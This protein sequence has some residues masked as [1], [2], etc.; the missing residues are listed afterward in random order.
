MGSVCGFVIFVSSCPFLPG[1][2]SQG[3]GTGAGG[4]HAPRPVVQGGTMKTAWLHTDFARCLCAW[5]AGLL[6]R[7]RQQTLRAGWGTSVT[8][9]PS[10]PAGG[11]CPRSG[12]KQG[13]Y[14]GVRHF[15]RTELQP[16]STEGPWAAGAGRSV[17]G[18]SVIP[19]PT[20]GTFCSSHGEREGGLEDLMIGGLSPRT[21]APGQ[22]ATATSSLHGKFPVPGP[23][24]LS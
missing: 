1:L 13:L 23:A 17:L 7:R 11:S 18:C 16:V 15:P 6:P 21:D 19:E 4:T 5:L 24:L 2:A 3:W 10:P 22:H 9:A 8:H 12:G 20:R 14:P